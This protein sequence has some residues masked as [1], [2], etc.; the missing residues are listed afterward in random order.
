MIPAAAIA[1]TFLL[2]VFILGFQRSVGLT[3]TG[4]WPGEDEPVMKCGPIDLSL[5][6]LETYPR[7][8]LRHGLLIPSELCEGF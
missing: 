2:S 4:R 7:I 3:S 6:H 5:G 1:A 8:Y